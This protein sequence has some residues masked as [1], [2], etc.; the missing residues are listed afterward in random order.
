[1]GSGTRI[2]EAIKKEGIEN[3]EKTILEFFEN[4]DKMLERERE[5]VNEDF[6]KRSDTYNIILGGGKMNSF[7]NV[8]VK[9]KD[10]NTLMVNRED[11]RYLSGEFISHIKGIK[12]QTGKVV[13]KDRN[14]NTFQVDRNDPRYL[15]GEFKHIL[16]GYKMN[17]IQLAKI[18]EASKINQSGSSNS[19]FGTTWITNGK[20]NKKIFRGSEIPEG[21][22]LGRKIK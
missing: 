1:M 2:K 9:D 16:V 10:G 22:K 11:S 13:V 5:I 18:S 6:I 12:R 8:V 17:E 14:G 3:F 7:N 15:S 19:Q 4:K 20:D 21:W